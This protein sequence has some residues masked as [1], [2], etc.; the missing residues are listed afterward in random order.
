MYTSQPLR[1]DRGEITRVGRRPVCDTG[2]R[3]PAVEDT[4]VFDA[5]GFIEGFEVPQVLVLAVDTMELSLEPW[6]YQAIKTLSSYPIFSS[7]FS[8]IKKYAEYH[9]F[10]ST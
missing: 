3:F 6:K 8:K 1:T 4:G 7:N 2:F 10:R 9:I 5:F